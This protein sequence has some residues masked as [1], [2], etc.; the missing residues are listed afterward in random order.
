MPQTWCFYYINYCHQARP[1]PKPK[2]VAIVCIDNEYMVFFIDSRIHIYIRNKPQLMAC[3]V[4]IKQADY[5][6]LSHDSYIDCS[7]LIEFN[8]FDLVDPRDSISSKTKKAIQRAVSNAKT[9][10]TYYKRLITQ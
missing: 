10:S 2:F 8:S 6:F 5:R 7:D 1:T 9:I 3:Q 4:L